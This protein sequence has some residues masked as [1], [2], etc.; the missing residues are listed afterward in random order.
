MSKNQKRYDMDY[1]AQAVKL[2][3]EVGAGTGTPENPLSPAEELT[4]LRKQIKDQNRKIKRLKEENESL[5]ESSAFF[6]A[7][8]RK[9]AN[10]RE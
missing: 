5:A 9:S 10:S 4:A 3:L 8:R 1:K 7:N 2:T 6:A